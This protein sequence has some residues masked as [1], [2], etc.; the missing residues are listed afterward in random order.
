MSPDHR[1]TVEEKV[2]SLSLR[3][4]EQ[5]QKVKDSVLLRP[6]PTLSVLIDEPKKI[7]PMRNAAAR[8]GA[9]S[10]SANLKTFS[11]QHANSKDEP[12]DPFV[13]EPQ[14]VPEVYN[15][16][17]DPYRA[18]DPSWITG[19]LMRPRDMA[20]A[21]FNRSR[22]NPAPRPQKK[23]ASLFMLK[24]KTQF[25]LKSRKGSRS[26]PQWGRIGRRLIR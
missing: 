2:M 6:A 25:V 20:S 7:L 8:A 11:S 16:L 18:P 15:G 21:P 10:F 9:N 12:L 22:Q 5:E 17:N 4:E 1:H 14:I 19:S 23:S 3:Q 24:K 26:M 13:S